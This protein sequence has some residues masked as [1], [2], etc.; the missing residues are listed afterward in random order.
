MLKY[1]DKIGIAAC[2]NARSLTEKNSIVRLLDTL[3]KLHFIP[4]LSS[5][6]YETDSTHSAP[7]KERAKALMDFH[8]DDSIKAIF[9]ISGGDIAN[10]IL[11]FLDYDCIKAH[12]KPF[13]GYS[14]LT[15]VLNALYQKTGNLSYLYQ[16]KNLIWKHGE[17]QTKNF[18]GSVL[19]GQNNLF[20]VR[21][22]FVQGKQMEGIVIG[23]NI[24]CFLKLA[25]TVYLPD[26]QNKL[27]FLESNSGK[28]E[29]MTAYLYQL[30]QL[31]AFD[32]ISGLLLGLSLI[33]IFLIQSRAVFLLLLH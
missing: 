17:E 11:E 2:S 28:T 6:I 32:R 24:R 22:Q 16:V 23:G 30:K 10:G 18:K 5:C 33:H 1:G 14:D 19:D 15:V 20:D 25:G 4:V 7:A 21:W 8:R 31:G 29:Q 27:L 12:P 3:E 9:D 26:F 13:W